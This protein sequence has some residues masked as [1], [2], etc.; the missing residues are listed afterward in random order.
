MANVLYCIVNSI[1]DCITMYCMTRQDNTI[2]CILLYCIL[3]EYKVC[4]CHNLSFAVCHSIMN[5]SMND[6]K[7]MTPSSADKYSNW[8]LFEESP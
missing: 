3:S 2:D 1:D 6:S 5:L 7:G 8:I 4:A